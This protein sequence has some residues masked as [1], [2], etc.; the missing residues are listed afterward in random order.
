MFLL[1]YPYVLV[2]ARMLPVC[3][4]MYPYVTRMLPVWCISHDPLQA[5]VTHISSR[6]TQP[7]VKEVSQEFLRLSKD[8]REKNSSET[9]FEE[10][11]SNFKSRPRARLYKKN[12]I[13]AT[14][15]EVR[16]ADRQ[17]ALIQTEKV[18]KEI[19]PFVTIYRPSVH[20]IE[21]Y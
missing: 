5:D 13:Q 20:Y 6:G 19:L 17:F 18:R 8:F 9:T 3:T 11:L 7:G 10:N 2:C 16:F 12:V 4:R 1:C 14:L 15:S 21:T